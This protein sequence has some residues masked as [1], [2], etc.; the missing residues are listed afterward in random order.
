M[1]GGM[2]SKWPYLSCVYS[3]KKTYSII[4]WLCQKPRKKNAS[5]QLSLQCSDNRN[6]RSH[7][8]DKTFET[9]YKAKVYN[10]CFVGQKA[11]IA[12]HDGSGRHRP[13]GST[14]GQVVHGCGWAVPIP[15]SVPILDV[16]SLMARDTWTLNLRSKA[17]HVSRDGQSTIALAPS[18]MVGNTLIF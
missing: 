7:P 5:F 11:A 10:F 8:R 16:L 15:G 2:V 12:W 14:L 13:S 17:P 6:P 18:S 3:L 1:Y 4:S 9:Y